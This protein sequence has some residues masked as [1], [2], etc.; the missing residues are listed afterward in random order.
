MA[1]KDSLVTIGKTIDSPERRHPGQ[2]GLAPQPVSSAREKPKNCYEK[3]YRE[4]PPGE[5]ERGGE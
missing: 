4:I 1:T 3:A 2:E 5:P